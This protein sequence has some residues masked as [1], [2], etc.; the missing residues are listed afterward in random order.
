[1]GLLRVRADR[2]TGIVNGIDEVAWNPETDPHLPQR[3]STKTIGV[4]ALNKAHIQRR[5][6]LAEHPEAPLFAV[7]SRL[8][9]QKGMD[10]LLAALPRVPALG[11]QLAV[12]GTGDEVLEQAFM[13]AANANPGVIGCVLRHEES[14]SHQLR[15]GADAILV[16]SR[17]EP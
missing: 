13:Q 4:R 15:G 6:G 17:F 16:P 9:W 11:A 8:A 3:Y 1:E 2:L 7:V 14:L 12:R 10:L 5:F